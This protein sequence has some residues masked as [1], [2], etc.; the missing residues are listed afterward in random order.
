MEKDECEIC[1]REKKYFMHNCPN[2]ID[3]VEIYG[4]PF[5]DDNCAYC[6]HE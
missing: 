5:C 6:E 1:G 2:S 4:C 3:Y